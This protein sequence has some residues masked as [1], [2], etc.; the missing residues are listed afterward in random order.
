MNTKQLEAVT[1]ILLLGEQTIDR[2]LFF[3]FQI[4][5]NQSSIR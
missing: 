1:Y 3:S 4:I 2:L 5:E